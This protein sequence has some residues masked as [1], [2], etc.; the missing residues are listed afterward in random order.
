MK[1]MDMFCSSP[2]ST[3]VIHQSSIMLRRSRSTKSYY[4]HERRKNQLHRAPCSS[5]LLLP[6]NPKPYFEKHRKSS[7][8]KQVNND[9]RRKSSVHVK[10]LSSNYPSVADSSRR[11]L[12]DDKPFIDWV[13]ESNKMVS[14]LDDKTMSM[15]M[16]RKDSHAL[17]KFS[18]S[19]LS[20]KDQVFIFIF[21]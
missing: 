5:Q 18:S 19:P 4:E 16:K 20:S 10:D 21:Y 6:I 15:D 3:E 11:Y 13:S 2:A 1:R 9:T 17:V 14:K 8:D 7:A 12:L